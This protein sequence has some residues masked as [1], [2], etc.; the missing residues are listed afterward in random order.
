MVVW[1]VGCGISGREFPEAEVS[2]RANGVLGQVAADNPAR[3][4]LRAMARA[5]GW[6]LPTDCDL[7][8]DTGTRCPDC[9]RQRRSGEPTTLYLIR[10]DRRRALKVGVA[11]HTSARLKHHGQR[12]WRVVELGGRQCR[13]LLRR[14][15]TLVIERAI[16]AR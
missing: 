1:L 5:M 7:N 14:A 2:V 10:S 16:V 13:W 11:G 6:F 4:A 12:G 3:A 8:D 9:S 15:D